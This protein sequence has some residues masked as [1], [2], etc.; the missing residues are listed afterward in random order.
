MTTFLSRPVCCRRRCSRPFGV[1]LI[2]VAVA[3]AVVSVALGMTPTPAEAD[4]LPPPAVGEATADEAAAAETAAAGEPEAASPIQA[5][6]DAT[7]QTLAIVFTVFW[8]LIL[9]YLAWISYQISRANADL[10]RAAANSASASRPHTA[11]PPVAPADDPDNPFR[12]PSS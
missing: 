11:V 3:V 6:R 5:Q 8:T 10:R 1:G 7:G 12:P 2:F 4:V 9:G